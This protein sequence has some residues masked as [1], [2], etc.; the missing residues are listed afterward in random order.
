[1][2]D[3]PSGLSPEVL[4]TIRRG[5]VIPAVPLALNANRQFDERRQRALIRYYIDSGVGGIAVGMHFTQFEIRDPG[6]DLF[7]PVLEVCSDEIDRYGASVGRRIA[8]IAGFSGG[9][10]SALDQARLSRELGYDIGIASMACFDGA[11]PQTMVHHVRRLADVMP[12]F[13]FYLLTGVGGIH[14]PYAFW[15]ELV[16]IENVIGIK[17]APFDRYGTID[18]ARALADSGRTQQ[19]TLYTGKDDSI[20]YDLLTPFRF[21]PP[22]DAIEVRIRGGLLGQWACWTRK[23]VELHER[24]LSLA[25]R[26]ESIT[27]EL[28]TLSAQIT[29]ANAALFDPQ[30]GFA[31]SIPGVN[32]VLR[33]QGFLEGNWTLKKDEVLSPGQNDEI[34]RV[35]EAYPHLTDDDFVSEN[36]QRWLA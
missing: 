22:E 29:D 4:T 7:R 14:L 19:I 18:V 12:M 3:Q 11:M 10:E 30:N 31:G 36:L 1:M 27:P 16:E 2:S 32:E 9:T 15:R 24:L 13:G 25:D 23:A 21:G 34:D 28:L 33:R 5:C 20:V 35:C 8:K 26:G 6:I 17:I